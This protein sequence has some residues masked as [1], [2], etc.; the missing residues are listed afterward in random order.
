MCGPVVLCLGPRESTAKT[1]LP[2]HRLTPA[3]SAGTAPATSHIWLLMEG[4]SL[5]HIGGPRSP[6]TPAGATP[7]PWAS[8]TQRRRGRGP[9][10]MTPWFF[11]FWRALGAWSSGDPSLSSLQPHRAAHSPRGPPERG[12]FPYIWAS[13]P[14]RPASLRTHPQCHSLRGALVTSTVFQGWCFE[15]CRPT[16]VAGASL[17]TS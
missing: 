7:S 14:P 9:P 4:P 15:T 8:T 6:L 2:S 5:M 10:S 13:R 11:P 12:T 1:L 17:L 3:S 16:T